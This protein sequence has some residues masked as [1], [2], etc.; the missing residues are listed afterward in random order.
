MNNSQSVFSFNGKDA[1]LEIAKGLPAIEQAITIEFWEKSGKKTAKSPSII[2]A[3]NA[4][5]K[6]VLNIYFPWENLNNSRMVWDAGNEQGYNRIHKQIKANHS[7]KVWTHWAFV[8]DASTGQMSIYQ[9]G[10][11]WYQQGGNYKSLSGIDRL[12]I[13]SSMDGL[14]C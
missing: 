7:K 13:G 9:N 8:K 10:K 12:V 4:Q 5:H 14:R 1:R 3:Q 2:E 6:R 11:I